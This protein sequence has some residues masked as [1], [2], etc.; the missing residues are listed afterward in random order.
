MLTHTAHSDV[1]FS[2]S[3]L[4]C[5]KHSKVVQYCFTPICLYHNAIMS[6]CWHVLRAIKIH[7]EPSGSMP[8]ACHLH[9]VWIYAIRLPTACHVD[10]CRWHTIWILAR[11]LDPCHAIWVYSIWVLCSLQT[12]SNSG[13]RTQKTCLRSSRPCGA[14]AVLTISVKYV[15]QLVSVGSCLLICQTNTE[16]SL[17]F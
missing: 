10:P 7:I 4:L 3:L 14:Y 6:N 17:M 5:H 2:F 16:A 9:A 12:V 11:I 13:V 1:L 8:S 15:P